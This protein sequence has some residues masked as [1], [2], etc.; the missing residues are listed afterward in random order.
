MV[1]RGEV[2]FGDPISKYLPLTHLPRWKERVPTLEE[3][4]THRA[5][6]PNAPHGLVAKE[7]AFALGLGSV[8]PWATLDPEDFRGRGAADETTTATR[9]RVSLLEPWLRF[10]RRGARGARRHALRTPASRPHLLSA[11]GLFT[12]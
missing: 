2:D 4:A 6:L 3:L 8:V 12:R 10:A 1:L 7:L 11:W 9:P 5:S